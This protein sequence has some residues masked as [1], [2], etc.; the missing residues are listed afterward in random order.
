[1]P[2]GLSNKV[3]LSTVVSGQTSLASAL[4]RVPGETRLWILASGERPPNPAELLS[5]PRIGEILSDLRE[6]VDFVLVDSPPVLPVADSVIVAALAD[7]VILV[8]QANA[9]SRPTAARAFEVLD[10][11]DSPI[12]GTVLNQ[13]DTQ[14]RY[15]Y[16]YGYGGSQASSGSNSSNGSN[17]SSEASGLNGT[18]AAPLLGSETSTPSSTH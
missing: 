14:S 2:F 1:V 12:V 11:V 8:V 5:N 18:K 7:A 6:E 4:Q 13:V 16:A 3:G 9:T 10:Q 15:G 17:G